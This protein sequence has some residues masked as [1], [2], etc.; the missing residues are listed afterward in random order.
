MRYKLGDAPFHGSGRG[1]RVAVIDSGVD[2]G[3]PHI[4]SIAGGVAIA[5][6]G[7]EHDDLLDRLGHGTAVMA[8]IQEKAPGAEIYAVKVF[9][10][11][12]TTR[13]ANI[14][15]GIDWAARNG[16]QVANLSLGTVREDSEA[17]LSL[18]LERAHAADLLVVSVHT[19][20]GA[21][22]WPGSLP[23]AVGVVAEESCLRDEIRLSTDGTGQSLVAAS[24]LPRPIEGVPQ[25]RNISGISFAVANA[26]GFLARAIEASGGPNMPPEVA[27]A[28]ARPLP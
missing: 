8:A 18:A 25:E 16:M 21:R 27:R 20:R 9:E 3:N 5:D 17:L 24:P 6:N 22:W 2:P 14:A 23:G 11:V 26:T 7:D 12:L 28:L 10:T 4:G 1:V 19:H 13:A 15:A